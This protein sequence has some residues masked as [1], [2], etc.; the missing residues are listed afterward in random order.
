MKRLALSVLMLLPILASAQIK[1]VEIKRDADTLM[2]TFS[3]GM[4]IV[5]VYK[6]QKGYFLAEES[7]N[8]FD[9]LIRFYLGED[10]S[11]SIE[12][13]RTMV[14]FCEEDVSTTIQ[15]QDAEGHPFT[16][17]TDAF[18][19]TTRRKPTFTPSTMIGITNKDLAGWVYYKKKALEEIIKLLGK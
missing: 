15:V 19:G 17:R 2:H 9:P 12:S 5:H 4:D 3:S 8:R 7:T 1:V 16:I 11:R 18:S 14:S 13:L 6:N 10:K